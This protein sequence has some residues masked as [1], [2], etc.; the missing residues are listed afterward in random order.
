MRINTARKSGENKRQVKK[1]TGIAKTKKIRR[2]T[3]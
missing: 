3:Q 1:I 2:R